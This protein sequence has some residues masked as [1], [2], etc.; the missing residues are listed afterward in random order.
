MTDERAVRLLLPL[1]EEPDGPP[2]IDVP[3]TMVE[4][5]RR[6]VLRRWS[7][8]AA[9]IALTSVAAGGGTLAVA[10]LRDDS[11]VPVPTVTA[12]ATASPSAVA[13]APAGP[14]GCRVTR[15]PTD[16][17]RKAVVTA[18]DPTGRY[19]AGRTYQPSPG[20]ILWKDGKILDRP[21]LTG[22][23]PR[24]ADINSSGI[25][26]GSA[27]IGER[28]QGYVYR[29]GRVSRLDGQEAVP[30]AINDAGVIVGSIGEVLEEMPVRWDSPDGAATPLPMPADLRS[31][32]AD[33][34]AEDGTVVGTVATDSR[35]TGSGYLWLPDGTG[36]KMDP[37]RIEGDVADYFW[38]ESISNGWV[39]GRAVDDSADGSRSFTSMRY[40]IADGTYHR[41][42]QTVFPALIAENGWVAGEAGPPL[43]LAGSE[44]VELPRYRTLKEYQITYYSADGRRVAGHST[45]SEA[46]QVGNEPLLWTCR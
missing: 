11:P 12:T 46:D 8:G 17:V 33:S 2:R 37:P 1:R 41:L 32:T 25:A 9:L 24:F 28:Q 18:G 44:V 27:F 19:L 34:I 39:A 10:A 15:L 7:G 4:G 36:R 26:V 13:A 3:R 23:D 5:R 20:P 21:R 14:V 43:I 42:P 35:A 29:D 16:G 30:A 40:R 45:D 31:G 6:R 22:D 38:P